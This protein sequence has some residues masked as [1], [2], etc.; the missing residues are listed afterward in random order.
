MVL[1]FLSLLLLAM[2]HYVP[3]CLLVHFYSQLFVVAVVA[4]VA[5]VAVV[6]V[7]SVVAVGAVVVVAVVAAAFRCNLSSNLEER[8]VS[9]LAQQFDDLKLV[10]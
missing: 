6:A 3:C 9:S 5:V 7:V 1:F 10:H 8:K 4:A 2:S